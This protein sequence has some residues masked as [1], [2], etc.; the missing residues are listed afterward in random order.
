MT[1]K[2]FIR[3]ELKCSY[4][5]AEEFIRKFRHY[6][7]VDYG[8]NIIQNHIDSFVEGF[9]TDNVDEETLACIAIRLEDD[10]LCDLSTIED[11]ILKDVFEDKYE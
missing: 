6:D 9:D 10:C 7:A 2:D 8:K 11:R 4:D 3:R 5:D 1:L